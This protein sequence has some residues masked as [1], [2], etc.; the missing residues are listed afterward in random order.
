M[1]NPLVGKS[2]V[3]S[4][5]AVQQPSFVERRIGKL[6]STFYTYLL[7]HESSACKRAHSIGVCER[8]YSGIECR[9]PSGS[10]SGERYSEP[11]PHEALRSSGLHNQ[12]PGAHI[13]QISLCDNSTSARPCLSRNLAFGSA[14]GFEQD[15][16]TTIMIRNLPTHVVPKQLYDCIVQSGFDLG[17]R[18]DDI[19]IAKGFLYV[20]MEFGRASTTRNC[21]I[22]FV[23]FPCEAKAATFCNT[24]HNTSYGPCLA[25]DKLN[26]ANAMAQGVKANARLWGKRKTN[27]IRNV[28]YRPMLFC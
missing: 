22:A 12:T 19:N 17:S 6:D 2:V 16:G 11:R 26:V 23:H 7:Q 13:N 8:E 25:E 10:L 1:C 15:L 3:E 20:P 21:G 18:V 9:N 27:R 24:W 4:S 28:A 14:T 5:L